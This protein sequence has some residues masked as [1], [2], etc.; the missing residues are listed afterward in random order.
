MGSSVSPAQ[1]EPQPS[2]MAS[3]VNPSA[4]INNPSYMYVLPVNGAL[5]IISASVRTHLPGSAAPLNNALIGR[6]SVSPRS[7]LSSHPGNLFASLNGYLGPPAFVTYEWFITASSEIQL[8]WRQR[9]TF[10]SALFFTNRYLSLVALYY[11]KIFS[12]LHFPGNAEVLSISLIL[13]RI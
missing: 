8:F 13:D 12:Y 9:F 10:A 2:R 4:L 3:Q 5:D 1:I 6:S 7:V 11:G